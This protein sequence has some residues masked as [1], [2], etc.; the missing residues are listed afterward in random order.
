MRN[1][2]NIDSLKKAILKKEDAL[3]KAKQ[4]SSRKLNNIG[5]GHSMRC[6]KINVSF[7]KED[8]L[9]DD[10]KQMYILLEE[11]KLQEVA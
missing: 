4:E 3:L 2:K 8:K 9:S 6:T 10:L 1:Y 7:T 11:M 5:F